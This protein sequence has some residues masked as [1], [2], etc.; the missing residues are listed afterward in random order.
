VWPAPPADGQGRL[1]HS[2]ADQAWW[3][4]GREPSPLPASAYYPSI[5]VWMARSRAGDATG[6]AVAAKGGTNAENHNH[7]DVGTVIVALDGTPVI[8]DAGRSTYTAQTFS[9]DRYAIWSMRSAWHNVPLIDGAEQNPGP[10]YRSAG[11]QVDAQGETSPAFRVD[12]A[13]AYGLAHL[14]AWHRQV[15]LVRQGGDRPGEADDAGRDGIVR[16]HDAWR[17]RPGQAGPAELR[18]LL[19]GRI[20]F[21]QPGRVDIESLSGAMATLEWPAE[22]GYRLV[23]KDLDDPAHQRVWGGQL[24]QLRLD[25]SGR[26][27]CTVECRRSPRQRTPGNSYGSGASLGLWAPARTLALTTSPERMIGP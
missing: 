25:V 2:L 11:A 12:L 13:G 24:T 26:E 7:N 10:E 5:E 8:V 16:I 3:H 22:I 4:A 27:E 21:D 9:P 14:E 23:A 19:A 18:F 1:A 6:W 20:R 17:W 15:C